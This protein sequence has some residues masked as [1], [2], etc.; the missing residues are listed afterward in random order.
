MYAGAAVMGYK[1]F[2]ES[3]ESQFTLNLPQDKVAT[4][5]AVWTT[6]CSCLRWIFLMLSVFIMH[7]TLFLT[8]FVYLFF[9]NFSYQACLFIFP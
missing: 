4:K 7:M 1:M 2:G 3:I 5:I 9:P 8:K 6:V